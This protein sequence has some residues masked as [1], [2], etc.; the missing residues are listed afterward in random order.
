M[1]RICVLAVLMNLLLIACTDAPE[2][3]S[4]ATIQAEKY[5]HNLALIA[6]ASKL[7]ETG[8]LILRAGVDFASEQAK[9]FSLEDKSYSH[10]GIAI[11]QPDSSIQIVHIIP[12]HY[13]IKDKVR[14]E[15]IDSFANPLD[16]KGIAIARYHLNTAQKEKFIAYLQQQYQQK[17]SFD[18]NFDLESNDKMYCSEMISK[19]LA[20]ASN[21]SLKTELV[22]FNDRTKLK[23]IKMYYGWGEDKVINKVIIPIDR[24][25]MNHFCTLV[26][27]YPFVQ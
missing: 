9:G 7:I 20:I 4:K 10:A 26:K 11:V 24:L 15:S 13:Y 17:V 8:D 1:N 12:D 27:R 25:Y 14:I 19:G 5:Q 6:E 3:K 2:I 23:M 16:N 18:L 22:K 21:D